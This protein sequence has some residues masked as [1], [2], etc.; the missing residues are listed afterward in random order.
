MNAMPRWN[1]LPTERR[2]AWKVIGGLSEPSKML[3]FGFGLPPLKTC[4]IGSH[5]NKIEGS[6]C[7][8]CYA[9]K[10]NYISYKCVAT[11][12]ERR[13]SLLPESNDVF[14]LEWQQWIDA[15]VHSIPSGKTLNAKYFRWHDAGDTHRAVY[16]EAIVEVAIR[17][18]DTS[19]W[20]P[21]KET[22]LWAS[23]RI[24][25]GNRWPSNLSV[26]VSGAMIGA[27]V[28]KGPQ[29]LPTS[30]VHTD[31]VASGAYECPAY[32]QDGQCDGRKAGGFLCTACFNPKVKAVS[33]PKH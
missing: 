17:R 25:Y 2:E 21:T 32:S 15:M 9:L 3:G 12:Q 22:K 7:Y 14:G 16:G 11:A 31:K 26:R 4:P 29:G 33:Y 28:F 27:R 13:L 10:G 1:H 24:L 23:L 18:P 30:L 20:V 5:L 6:S 19:Y 8:D